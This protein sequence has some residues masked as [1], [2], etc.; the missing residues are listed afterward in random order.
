MTAIE[1][2]NAFYGVTVGILLVIAIL[3]SGCGNET[4]PAAEKIDPN[5]VYEFNFPNVPW[6][7]PVY[8]ADAK[9]FFQKHGLKVH[10]TGYLANINDIVTNVASGNFPFACQHAS[11]LAVGISN[12]YPIKAV[13]AGWGT[14]AEKPMLRF[15]TLKDSGINTLDD[16]RGHKIAIPTP[17]ELEWLEAKDK[18]HLADGDVDETIISYEKMDGALLSRQ[19]DVLMLI[20]PFSD[21]LLMNENVKQIGTLVDIVGEEKGWPQQFVNT[22]F[23]KKNPDIVKRYVAAIADANDWARANPEEAG[24]VIAKALDVDPSQG[25]LYNPVFPEHALIDK[26][27]AELWVRISGK[28]GLL[29]RPVSLDELYTNEYNPYYN[30]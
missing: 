1:R 17:K 11:T 21:R 15:L 26:A 4:K 16:I 7:D 27:D 29:A 23:L 19:V 6:S 2:K 8:I 14:S 13:A 12:G 22:E 9:G 30:K 10:F 28:Y 25:A 20:N 5:G 3:L 18:L 24:L